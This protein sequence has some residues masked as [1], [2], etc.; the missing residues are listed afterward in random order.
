MLHVWKAS[1]VTSVWKRSF[2]HHVWVSAQSRWGGRGKQMFLGNMDGNDVIWKTLESMWVAVSSCCHG[3]V[4]GGGGG[5]KIR[6]CPASQSLKVGSFRRGRHTC[7][8]YYCP[9]TPR[10]RCCPTWEELS[11]FLSPPPLLPPLSRMMSWAADGETGLLNTGAFDP[12]R[13]L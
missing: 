5:V 10:S 3:D 13:L 12:S 4:G 7:S 11:L 9:P 6:V 2:F 1:K 8:H